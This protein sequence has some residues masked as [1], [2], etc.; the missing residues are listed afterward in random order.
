MDKLSILI[1]E[2]VEGDAKLIER[3]LGAGGIEFLARRVETREEFL[4]ALD[5]QRPDV[6]L[7]DYNLPHF[8]GRVALSLALERLPLVPVIIVTGALVD[9]DAVELL[10][11]GASDYIL[12]DRLSRLAP[13]VRRARDDARAK[14][15]RLEDEIRYRALFELSRDGIVLIDTDTGTVTDCNPEFEA[16]TGY[17]FERLKQLPIWELQPPDRIEAV[18]GKFQQARDG[19]IAGDQQLEWH[20][21]D[22]TVLLIEFRT[23]VIELGGKRYVQAQ[24]RDITERVRAE[25]MLHA[26]IDE[27]RRFQ[28]VTVDRELR[29]QELEERLARAIAARAKAA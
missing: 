24:V 19:N 15:A 27:L 6:I 5:E 23:K 28:K 14:A 11:E 7:A 8:D 22:G 10:R 13:A 21:P 9:V 4:R 12:K 26:Q 1:V 17:R 25:E 16:Q 20:R 18:R 3:A 2:D 29:M